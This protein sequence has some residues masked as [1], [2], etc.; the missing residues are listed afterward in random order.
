MNE[1][2]IN[3]Y[4]S[5]WLSE[6]MSIPYPSAFTIYFSTYS[7]F[8]PWINNERD[9]DNNIFILYQQ[10]HDSIHAEIA[11]AL[12]SFLSEYRS[13]YWITWPIHVVSNDGNVVKYPTFCR[14]TCE[15]I[16][17]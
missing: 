14:Q 7:H 13:I 5:D 10:D 1:C 11:E 16:S 4:D 9:Y 3:C 17:W 15:K 6:W 2:Q 8:K 12:T